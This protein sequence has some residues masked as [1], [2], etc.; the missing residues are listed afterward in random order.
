MESSE[1]ICSRTLAFLPPSVRQD[2]AAAMQAASLSTPRMAGRPHQQPAGQTGDEQSLPWARLP[3]PLASVSAYPGVESL[4]SMAFKA[5]FKCSQGGQAGS[6]SVL[7]K[8]GQWPYPVEV[9]GWG[10][11][12][13]LKVQGWQQQT[14]AKAGLE[15]KSKTPALLS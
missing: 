2:V 3:Y 14:R 10:G 13:E 11:A 4:P 15:G 6:A 7:V 8:F 1:E 9:R 5:A 12:V